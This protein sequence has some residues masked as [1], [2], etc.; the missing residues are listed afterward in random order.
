MSGLEVL[1]GIAGFTVTVLVVVAMILITPRGQVDFSEQAADPRLHRHPDLDSRSASAA[2]ASSERDTARSHGAATR[3]P[4]QL[5]SPH[6]SVP[7]SPE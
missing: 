7:S 4:H 5:P 6:R 1:V 2:M 3:F